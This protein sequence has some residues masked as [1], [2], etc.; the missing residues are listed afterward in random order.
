MAILS[1]ADRDR[2]VTIDFDAFL[3]EIAT[4]AALALADL[5]QTNDE[6]ETNLRAAISRS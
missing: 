2:P 1:Q 6:I 4:S 5:G 3:R